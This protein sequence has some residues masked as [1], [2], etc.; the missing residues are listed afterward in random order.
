MKIKHFF[1][2][3]SLFVAI[4]FSPVAVLADHND[5]HTIQQLQSQL[6]SLQQ[7]FFALLAAAATP[8]QPSQGTGTATQPAVPAKKAATSTA[9]ATP[10]TPAQPAQPATPATS[11]DPAATP[12][13]PA[14]P[15][16]P[17]T[18]AT[19][20]ESA[21]P[22]QPYPGIGIP[23]TPAQPAEIKKVT[24]SLET[25]VN[26]VK[27]KLVQQLTNNI[28]SLQTQ[29]AELQSKQQAISRGQEA[30]PPMP[31][32]A[33]TRSLRR[34]SS[35]D[36]VKQ[37]Q[38]FLAQDKDVYPQGLA[39]GFF[40]PATERA[41]KRFQEK[42]GIEPVGIVG[43]ITRAKLNERSSSQPSES[44][45]SVP[46]P[47]RPAE[48][49]KPLKDVEITKILKK[50]D[51]DENVKK[52][53]GFMK[54]FPEI[55]PNGL[56]TGFYGE[57]TEKAVKKFQEKVGIKQTGEV[58]EKTKEVLNLLLVAGEKKKPPKIT[59]V[60]PA[61][62]SAGITVT[63]TGKGFTPKSNSIMMRGKI[64]ATGLASYD[65]NTQIDFILTPDISCQ[66]GSKKACPIKVVNANGISNAKPFKL[67]EFLL[68][69]P[70]I[71][72]NT[73]PPEPAPAPTPTPT[74]APSPTD[75]TAPVRSNG[76][77]S[78]DLAYGT[79]SATLSL[80]TDEN[81]TC[82]YATAA[83]IVYNSMTLQFLTTG[84][85]SHSSNL[86]S[87]EDGKSYN[88]HNRCK[89]S[90][91]NEN[92]DDFLIAFSVASPPK[93]VVTSL[94]PSKGPV[95]TTVTING[96]AFTATGNSVNF[97][98]VNA[99]ANLSSADGKTLVFSVPTGTTC[100][101][102]ETCPV[103]VTNAN[104][105]S[106]EVS[107]L[108]TQVITLVKMVFPNGGENLVQGVDFTLSWTG[109]TDRVDIILVEE[110]ATG[111]SDPSEF[112]VGRIGASQ[113]PNSTINWNA[114]TV[115]SLDGTVCTDIAPGKYKIMALSE[116]E[117]GALTIWNDAENISGN[118][119]LSNSAF[120]VSP[121]ATLTVVVP[122]GGEIGSKNSA[123]IVCWATIGLKSKAV[124]I[125]LLKNGAVYQTINSY[126]P[127]TSETGAFITNWVIPDSIPE[128]ADYQIKV[129]DISLPI[130]NDTS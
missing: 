104:G 46:S 31:E 41:V 81:A 11:A 115:C 16:Q 93:P 84:G 49:P 15:A 125:D 88:Y 28:Q 98:G 102:G 32:I 113:K 10:A 63:L 96:S 39:T 52:V 66:A 92:T 34:G 7:A 45:V 42:N 99:A 67:T 129:S 76:L 124:K 48:L 23:A 54:E 18:P 26:E 24:R 44:E 2:S 36:D 17:A 1:L 62:G 111:G 110:T 123:F 130:Q 12:A 27:E 55:Y 75:I 80:A 103:S 61:S 89:D 109:G 127:Q 100:Q 119:D 126:Y 43:P 94:L 65:N 107:F 22:A 3:S 64:I 120:T 128:G 117:I 95:G 118:W 85:V 86:T 19:P 106:N 53:Q 77:P 59:D 122:N 4:A 74:P 25:Q 91:N 38:E 50:G 73:P 121:S 8:A 90:A 37:L 78:G 13:I 21:T 101:I 83:G 69:P 71:D 14:T 70:E 5:F 79:R 35:G 82:K 51:T 29:V 33:L 58:D 20:A 40:G 112:I 114:K 72:P 56:A 57:Q 30:M 60:T 116:D 9:P 87:L 105:A 47:K 6:A 108:M 97:A 68:T